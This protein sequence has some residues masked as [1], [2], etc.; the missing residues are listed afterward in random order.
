MKIDK[1]FFESTVS[2]ATEASGKVFQFIQGEINNA[3]DEAR[4]LLGEDLYAELSEQLFDDEPNARIA[5][6]V[7]KWICLRAYEV[8]IPHRDLVLTPTGFGI[9]SNQNTSPASAERVN[10]LL[11]TV[12]NAKEDQFDIIL[13]ML[14]GNEKW[15][16]TPTAR[17]YFSSLFWRAK[18]LSRY[19]VADAHRS[20]LI[21][22]RQRIIAAERRL[23]DAISPEFYQELCDAVRT[24]SVTSWQQSAITS[25]MNVIGCEIDNSPRESRLHC[26]LLIGYLADNLNEYPTY[27]NSSAYKANNFKSYENAVNDSCFFF[28]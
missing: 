7:K 9:V 4:E 15:C 1:D 3:T 13:E 11:Q 6:A 18:Q 14:R 20:Q 17:F 28:G 24:N 8:A 19:G 21:S 26:K 25:C 22:H 2:S 10:R 23:K 5:N 27:A 12:K 16:D